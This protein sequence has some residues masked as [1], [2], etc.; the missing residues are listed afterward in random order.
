MTFVVFACCCTASLIQAQAPDT[1]SETALRGVGDGTTDV[2]DLLQQLVDSGTGDI[3]LPRG[4]YRITRPIV[5]NLDQV[6]P[7]SFSG[8][9]TARILMDGAGPAI[10]FVGTHEGTAAPSTFKDNVWQN[11]RSPMVDGLE[12]VGADPD[13][14]GIEATGTMQLTVTRTVIR[15]V[16]HGMHLV[17]RNRNVIIS[18]CH[19]YENRG[20]GVFYD[21]VDLHQSN[22]IGSHISYN[23]QGGIVARGGG[24]RNI[25]IGTCDI[26]GNMGGP[27]SEPTANVLLDSTGGSIAEVAIVGC[28]IQ[29]EHPSPN[30]ANIR[31][32]GESNPVTFTPETHHGNITI[33]DNVLSDVQVNI[34]V[35]NTR[36][37]AITGNTIWKGYAHNLRI[38][39]SESVV[40]S[41]NVIDRNPRYHYGDGKDSSNSLVIEK[42]RAVQMT[43]NLIH[44]AGN[45][46]T[47]V[48][49]RDSEGINITDMSVFDANPC[50]L[51]LVNVTG[52]RVSDC[53]IRTREG[54]GHSIIVTGGG[55][56]MVVNNLLNS[57]PKLDE[58]S[59][60]SSGNVIGR[61]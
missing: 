44:G 51:E 21:H 35:E 20:V 26:E 41:G 6:G 30:S 18:D 2:S 50:G 3:T 29:H 52:S 11:Q 13:A 59:V 42:C 7:T 54:K 14:R 15:K 1:K 53:L 12:I 36:G 34:D 46:Q 61:R 24:V 38:V 39:N 37:I 8:T 55:G 33:A 48:T 56:N 31:I 60:H 28:T 57:M 23:Q 58:E 49:I 27:D 17:K 9:G 45:D 32:N 40:V 19:I 5:V 25:H 22:I 10:R 47:S 4:V 16:L 43:G